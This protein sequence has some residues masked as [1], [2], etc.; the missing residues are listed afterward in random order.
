MAQGWKEGKLEQMKGEF[1]KY[2]NFIFTDYRGLN[3]E[4]ITS[5]RAGLREK[6]VEYHVVKNRLAKRAFSAL[7]YVF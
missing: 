7:G 6:E 3:V 5:L 2:S 1:K 4:Q